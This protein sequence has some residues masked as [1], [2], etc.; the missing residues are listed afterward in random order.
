MF[1]YIVLGLC[2]VIVQY[3]CTVHG[4]SLFVV[5][6][7]A[8]VTVS[9]DNLLEKEQQSIR[10]SCLTDHDQLIINDEEVMACAEFVT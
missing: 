10:F 7:T 9:N 5:P 8:V 6:P 2:V 4:L 1:N 3:A